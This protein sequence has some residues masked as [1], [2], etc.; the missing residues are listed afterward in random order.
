MQPNHERQ[1]KYLTARLTE[2]KREQPK[3]ERQAL[4]KRILIEVLT[5]DLRR[6]KRVAHNSQQGARQ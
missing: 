5:N 3:N 1:I 4:G 6:V 2:I